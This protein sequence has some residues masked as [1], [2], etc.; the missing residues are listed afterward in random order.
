MPARPTARTLPILGAAVL[1]IFIAIAGDSSP[2][3]AAAAAFGHSFDRTAESDWAV[4]GAPSVDG[5][6]G[7]AQVYQRSGGSWVLAATLTPPSRGGFARFGS[8]VAVSGNTLVVGAPW[9][10]GWRGAA[11]IYVRTAGTWN[12]TSRLTPRGAVG[13]RFGSRVAIENGVVSVVADG[14]VIARYRQTGAEWTEA[15]RVSDASATFAAAKPVD[16][17]L[18]GV[19]AKQDLQSG[20][21]GIVASSTVIAPPAFVTATDSTYEDRS[22]IRWAPVAG[23]PYLFKIYRR[24]STQLPTSNVLIRVASQDDSFYAD[25]TGI[26]GVRYTYCVTVL[27]MA[28]TEGAARCDDGNRIIFRPTGFSASDATFEKFVQLKW[29]DRSSIEA[30]YRIRRN[31][32]LLANTA[33]D[34]EA[35]EDSSAVA[36]TTYAYSL[37]PFDAAG[38]TTAVLTDNG[39][40]AFIAAPLLVSAT[41]GQDPNKVVITWVDNTALEVN[42]RV[43][44]NG[45]LRITLPA[46]AT[47]FDDLTAVNGTAYE[48]C[49][50]AVDG[51]ARESARGCDFGGIGVLPA[52]ARVSATD[53]TF[54]D[55]VTITWRDTST[56]EDGFLVYRMPKSTTDSILV[57]NLGAGATTFDDPN[58]QPG[59]LYTYCVVA[60]SNKGGRSTPICDDGQRAVVIAPASVTATDGAFEDRVDLTWESTSSSAVLFKL[61]RGGVFIRSVSGERRTYSDDGGASGVSSIY[62][63]TAV[64]ALGVESPVTTDNGFRRIAVPTGVKA[65]DN[66]FEDHVTVSWTDRSEIESG[67]FVYRRLSGA[68]GPLQRLTLRPADAN[69]YDDQTGVP[70]QQYDY[71]VTAFQAYGVGKADTTESDSTVDAGSRAILAPTL[72]DATDGKFENKIVVSWVDNSRYEEAY[73]VWR[74]NLATND[75]SRVAILPPNS[76]QMIDSTITFGAAY[77]YSV[78]AVDSVAGVL[79]GRSLAGKDVGNT[80][81]LPPASVSASALYTDRVVVAWIDQSTRETAYRI[82]RDGV[83]FG[84][85]AANAT[86]FTDNSAASGTSHNYCVRAVNAADS[87]DNVCD[88]GTVLPAGPDPTASEQ[89]TNRTRIGAGS[90]ALNQDHFGRSIG[91]DGTRIIV[92]LP[93]SNLEGYGVGQNVQ[94]ARVTVFVRQDSIYVLEKIFGANFV[95]S[96]GYPN[97]RLTLAGF[98]GG[99]I[100]GSVALYGNSALVAHT[101]KKSG[102][103]GSAGICGDAGTGGC[104]LFDFIERNPST[105]TWSV[106]QTVTGMEGV[107]SVDMNSQWAVVGGTGSRVDG[108]GAS[109]PQ[110]DGTNSSI[111]IFRRSGTS[112]VEAQ[113]FGE[114]PF[115]NSRYFGSSVAVSDSTIIVGAPSN[116]PAPAAYIY[117]ANAAGAWAQTQALPNPASATGYFG[118]AVTI[119]GI[120]AVVGDP[121]SAQGSGSAFVYV[122][123]G[124]G[125]WSLETTLRPVGGNVGE[126]F[127]QSV[128]IRGDSIMVGCPGTPQGG[129][130]YLFTRQSG[131]WVRRQVQSSDGLSTGLGASV[132]VMDKVL[133]AGADLRVNGLASQAGAVEILIDP[134]IY[135]PAVVSAT[136]GTYKDK[137]QITWSDNFSTE[138]GFNVYRDGTLI[139]TTAANDRSYVDFDAEPGRTSEYCV[140][141][142]LSNGVETASSCDFGR[143][144]PDGNITGRVS[145]IAGAGVSGAQ[146]TLDP[147][148]NRA[149]LLDGSG[150]TLT[151]PNGSVFGDSLTVEFWYRGHEASTTAV[152]LRHSTTTT[153]DA[154]SVINPGNLTVLVNGVSLASGVP[155]NDGSWHHVAIDRTRSSGSLHVYKDGQLAFTGTLAAAAKID[156]IGALTFGAGLSGAMDDIRVWARILPGSEVNDSKSLVLVGNEH[157][158]LAY[159][160]LDAYQGA[161]AEDA[162][163]NRY[164]RLTGGSHWIPDAAPL[165]VFAVSDGQGN[166]VLPRIRYGT[167]T[168]FKVTP[169]IEGHQF[170]PA[171][172]TITLST[173]NPVQNE[174]GFIDITS[175]TASG[176]VSYANTSC[177]AANVEIYVDGVVRGTTDVSGRYAVPMPPGNHTLEARAANHTFSPAIVNLTDVA[178]DLGNQNFSDVTVRHLEG[179]VAG[180][181]NIPIGTLTIAIESQDRCYSRTISAAG[182]YLEALP[183]MKFFVRV[184]NVTGVGAGLDRAKVIQFFDNLGSRE[185][186]LSTADQT[187]DFKYRAPLAVEISGLPDVDPN[188]TLGVPVI[189]QTERF[190][191]TIKVF[192]DYGPT[193]G[194]C[195]VDTGTVTVFDEIIDQERTP[196][197]LMIKNGEAMVQTA[198][199]RKLYVTAANKPNIFEGRVDALGHDRSY[200]KSLTAVAE[201]EGQEPVTQIQWAIV[202][203][204]RPRTATFTAESQGIPLLVLHDPP[205]DHSFSYVGQDSS[206]CTKIT[207][208]GMQGVSEQF[209]FKV[210]FGLDILAGLFVM[211]PTTAELNT[212]GGLKVGFEATQEDELE[213]CAKTTQEFKTSADNLFIGRDG[214]V[215]VGLALNLLFAKTDVVRVENCEVKTSVE[216]TLGVDKVESVYSYTDWHIRNTIIPQLDELARLSP[217]N[218]AE[219]TAAKE[220]WQQHLAMNDSLTRIAPLDRNRSFSAGA[221]YSY[222]ETVDQSRA[223][224]WKVKVFTK[225]EIAH[226]FDFKFAGNGAEGEFV[227]ELDFAYE[228]G[229]SRTVSSSRT[230]GYT[231]SDDDIGDVFSVNVKKDL[232]YGTPIFDLVG[233]TS[234]CPWEPW[235]DARTGQ[236]HSQ[237]VDGPLMTVEPPVRNSVPIGSPAVFTLN[238][239]NDSQSGSLREYL[240][241]PLQESNPGGAII[242]I[243]GETLPAGLSFFLNPGETR[244]ATMTIE[245]GPTRYFYDDIEIAIMAPCEYDLFRNGGPLHLADTVKV[246]VAFDAPCSDISLLR[247]QP[248]WSVGAG[249]DSLDLILTNFQLAISEKDSLVS[250]GAEYQRAGTDQWLPV[251][252]EVPAAAVPRDAQGNPQSVSIRWSMPGVPEGS[253]SV[254]AFTRCGGGENAR[255][256]S[257][258]ASGV[259]DRAAPQVFGTPQPADGTLSLGEDISVT[260]NEDIDCASANGATVHLEAV[261]P[262]QAIAATEGCNGRTVVITPTVDLGAYEG[263]Q[264]RATV[265][266]IRDKV[267]NAFGTR[268]W[269]FTVRQGEIAWAQTAVSQDAAYGSGGRV[270]ASLVNGL[271]QPVRYTLSALPLWLTAEAVATDTIPAKSMANVAFRITPTTAIGSYDTTITAT[272]IT[273]PPT[274]ARNALLHVHVNVLRVPP[275]WSL[276]AADYEQSMTIRAKVFIDADS[277]KTPDDILAAFVGDQ[278]RGIA[279]PQLVADGWRYFLTVYGKPPAFERIRF[280]VWDSRTSKTYTATDKTVK[281]LA[282]TTYGAY[283][284]ALEIRTRQPSA[285][286]EQVIPVNA[287]WTWF[288]LNRRPSAQ[289]DRTVAAVL[290]NLVPTPGDLVKAQDG[291]IAVFDATAGWIGTLDTLGITRSYR[292]KT[293]AG[294][295]IR[296]ESARVLP[297]LYP[298]PVKKGWNWIGYTPDDARA[299]PSAL[300]NY[301]T[302]ATTDILRSQTAF[303]EFSASSWAGSLAS[304]APGVGYAM[305]RS[306]AADAQYIYNDVAAV[307]G[308]LP[309]GEDI[310][311]LGVQQLSTNATTV[312]PVDLPG[313]SVDDYAYQY[314][315]VVTA[316][317]SGIPVGPQCE[318]AAIVNGE[319]RGVA[320]PVTVAALGKT[321][322]FLMVRSNQPHGETVHFEALDRSTGKVYQVL[323]AATFDADAVIGSTTAPVALKSDGVVIATLGLPATFDLAQS[324]PNPWVGDGVATIRYGL[325]SAAHVRLELFDVSGRRV[326]KVVDAM[327]APGWYDVTIEP[328]GMLGGVYFCR[329]TAGSFSS[330]RRMVVVR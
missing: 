5:F 204:Q 271:S 311:P 111:R 236:P 10:E 47:T 42:Y 225:A 58:G 77:E 141:A 137:V 239:T 139:T 266:G 24:L 284:R 85:A 53:G 92:G 200:Q 189:N 89:F 133:A 330:T 83:V 269:T 226:S 60:F 246:N 245:R 154:F 34:V 254:R 86:S 155:V 209:K 329:M 29:S 283:G 282:D 63:V 186:D 88:T 190:P 323:G 242:K 297:S 146:V 122:R 50:A 289:D 167:S 25:A 84:T 119:S 132:K 257:G 12:L 9:D 171:F 65:T 244:Q 16:P 231:L 318:I 157:A 301:T 205:G 90:E 296:Y 197:V 193:L 100:G 249:A 314:D 46:G 62:A 300:I 179:N 4:V 131:T 161:G 213:I 97:S 127:G 237:P 307:A 217:A 153:S 1:A 130:T 140:S 170:N 11:Y 6:R 223:S 327:Q 7:A 64:T 109:S 93:G 295:E 106:A 191:M 94:D 211:L 299:V 72:V 124:A 317:L 286:N 101:G 105:G 259:I 195:P 233:G 279:H 278:V 315:M 59:Q 324:R 268:S 38:D 326:R 108:N 112:W 27:D 114:S 176:I 68:S 17:T 214:D 192:E 28:N 54:D 178:G 102:P 291:K 316:Q 194:R 143:R 43:Y 240:V 138:T 20:A 136:D 208:L 82:S 232:L 212:T 148:P 228:R 252:A 76:N 243:D 215:Y 227:T 73:H 147:P 110:G 39:Q 309:A 18:V 51:S 260:F 281:F 184:T 222:S 238:M 221:E 287:G 40:S 265:T 52:P 267:G 166:Y 41:D 37:A 44:R 96:P 305:Y 45:A 113:R 169:V 118:V 319:I 135:G 328:R 129:V 202:T 49:V 263:Q 81:I 280:R 304:M 303:S 168:T 115:A 151:V 172:K 78:F 255:N 173:G 125:V 121:L 150:G 30:G 313:W 71:F 261:S 285:A 35:Y 104:S 293:A 302:A 74:R 253:Y 165:T 107:A 75:S 181:C 8:S 22:E 177:L 251:G 145:T 250:V 210:H 175:F 206:F 32:V 14:G 79:V 199:G 312:T 67:Y 258:T 187:L 264:L 120:R 275:T 19:V 298:I 196:V 152:L 262:L 134:T 247:P 91:G 229:G 270:A 61:Y 55:K 276:N 80:S 159:W 149:L 241:L 183:P 322:V 325:P 272:A 273:V 2:T 290:S 13:D 235:P 95:G 98:I 126:R 123:D 3:S 158:L 23:G 292:I 274:F 219:F 21:P 31:G 56:T 306:N 201:V 162:V 218:N 234:S 198:N 117:R 164:G 256:F 163:G 216:V 142:L 66:E 230:S 116:S 103:N 48:Y 36:G 277:S 180:G 70:G 220:N 160:P 310:A 224:S 57:A 288:S 321:Y 128:S 185:V 294:G 308:L 203:G 182:A 69:A 33:P 156:S 320:R 248:G 144:P 188:C 174:V 99:S 15:E 87:S 26:P 207:N